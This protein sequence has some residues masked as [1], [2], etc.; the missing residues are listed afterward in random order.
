M[1]FF[2]FKNP[3]PDE[4]PESIPQKARE[5]IARYKGDNVPPIEIPENEYVE[6]P[7]MVLEKEKGP[8]ASMI[9]PFSEGTISSI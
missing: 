5:H 8:S 3:L 6:C 7:S 4:I 2:Y 1:H 9:E